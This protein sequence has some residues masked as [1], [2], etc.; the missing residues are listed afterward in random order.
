MIDEE[1]WFLG[2]DVA[3]ALGY[4]IPQK[5]VKD[6][7]DEEDLKTLKYKAFSKI[8]R[9]NLWG[10]NDFSDKILINESGLYD[11]IF[12]SELDSAKAFRKWVT[13]EVL[14]TL[15]RSGVYITES[16]TQEAIN[17]ESKY[18]KNKIRKTFRETN[19]LEETWQT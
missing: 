18:G 12:S 14:P 13:G 17:F 19:N 8:E 3:T 11:L 15:R 16:A 1:A 4:A 2:K 10:E 9:P 5:A 7:V 6:H